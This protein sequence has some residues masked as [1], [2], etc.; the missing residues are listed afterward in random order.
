MYRRLTDSSISTM[1][2]QASCFLHS[3]LTPPL[4]LPEAFQ[5]TRVNSGS[6]HRLKFICLLAQ[7][8]VLQSL[9]VLCPDILYPFGMGLADQSHYFD[10]TGSERYLRMQSISAK[11]RKVPRKSRQLFTL[12]EKPYACMN[13]YLTWSSTQPWDRTHCID[14]ETESQKYSVIAK[15]CRVVNSKVEPA[16]YVSLQMWV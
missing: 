3:A 8:P 15:V 4:S 6:Q 10:L 12:P 7:L 14:E 11:E 9:W 1:A 13:I 2:W 16:R 5:P